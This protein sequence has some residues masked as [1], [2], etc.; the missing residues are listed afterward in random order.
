MVGS[1][2]EPLGPLGNADELME[3]TL[4]EVAKLVARLQT[5]GYTTITYQQME[6][7]LFVGFSDA[8]QELGMS[9]RDAAALSGEP[10]RTYLD[11]LR[12]LRERVSQTDE[13][14][15]IYWDVLLYVYQNP[16]ITRGQLLAHFGMV[17]A[18]YVL[19]IIAALRREKRIWVSG[20]KGD[21][22][23]YIAPKAD[24]P[25]NDPNTISPAIQDHLSAM[26]EVLVSSTEQALC[27][28][29]NHAFLLTVRYNESLDS[30]VA[31]GLQELV[32]DF[33]T[34]LRAFWEQSET[35]NSRQR[36][37]QLTIYLGYG[38][39]ERPKSTSDK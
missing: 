23:I 4:R 22:T 27:G 14:P 21:A 12:R 18:P 17:S 38:A 24:V 34:K 26:G 39:Q 5:R 33:V 15:Q 37:K 29:D 7:A 16:G 10:L 8:M 28:I 2:P 35:D 19:S 9:R 32:K 1:T 25:D 11:K 6:R 13:R 36:D 3:S 20:G 30:P 31:V